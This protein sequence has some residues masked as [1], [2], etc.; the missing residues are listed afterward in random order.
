MVEGTV[1]F[2][3]DEKG[4]GFIEVEGEDDDYFFHISEIDALTVNEG[5]EVEFET[6]QGDRGP[7]AVN[8]RKI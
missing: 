6:E 7:R 5:D 1:K 2:F 4:Y 3:H 8:V